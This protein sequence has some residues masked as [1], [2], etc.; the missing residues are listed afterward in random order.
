MNQLYFKTLLFL[1]RVSYL[2]QKIN[3]TS[4]YNATKAAVNYLNSVDCKLSAKEKAVIKKYL[5]RNLIT[6]I[7]YPF[8]NE[9]L[10]RKVA[11][12]FDNDL[13][14]PYVFHNGKKL[15]FKK[16]MAKAKIIS[17]YNTLCTEQDPRS[18]HS[19][20]FNINYTLVD[21]AVDAGA[22]EGIWSLDIIDKVKKIYLFECDDEWIEAL[23][24]TFLPW[25]NK[26]QIVKKFVSNQSDKKNIRLDD[27]FLK[28]GVYPTILKAD[29][30]GYEIALT[31]GS[32]ELLS[33]HLRHIILCTYHNENDYQNLSAIIQQYNFKIETT[34]GYMLVI[35][36][37]NGEY[38][39]DDMSQRFRKGLIHGNR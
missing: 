19:Y 32:S 1:K 30:E 37:P 5:S 14:L 2:K 28:E 16:N 35:Y 27:Y 23:Q 29:I 11:V 18:P 26:V 9:Y 6:Q 24:A 10:F 33:K 25:K 38:Y 13:S 4:R 8:V 3:R 21:I 17:L 12:F 34:N 22:A 7:C 31:E 20:Q 36:N 39:E 15:Y